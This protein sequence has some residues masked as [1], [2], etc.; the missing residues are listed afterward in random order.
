MYKK[1]KSKEGGKKR[2]W[3]I[4]DGLKTWAVEDEKFETKGYGQ[5]KKAYSCFFKTG[6]NIG[7]KITVYPTSFKTKVKF[8]KRAGEEVDTINVRILE[9]RRS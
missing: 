8:G 2:R 3:D 7:Y 6:D 5:S 1:N 4:E 9:M